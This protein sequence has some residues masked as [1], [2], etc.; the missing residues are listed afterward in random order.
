MIVSLGQ[1]APIQVRWRRNGVT[2]GGAATIEFSRWIATG[3]Q[4]WDF[5]NGAWQS[6]V[7]P[8]AAMT[9]DTLADAH[10]YVLTVPTLWS[11]QVVRYLCRYP[12][13]ATLMDV[14]R[15]DALVSSRAVARQLLTDVG[16]VV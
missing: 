5:V 4:W 12:G 13:E 14:L 6:T 10:L 15:V 11:D 16:R 7:Q 3:A 8:A 9:F 1:R 2:L